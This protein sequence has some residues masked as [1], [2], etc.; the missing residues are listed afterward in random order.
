M[1]GFEM[2]KY[3]ETE[4]F[5]RPTDSPLKVRRR[6][7]TPFSESND[8]AWLVPGQPCGCL[9]SCAVGQIEST[10]GAEAIV[11]SYTATTPVCA[12]YGMWFPPCLIPKLAPKLCSEVS[13]LAPVLAGAASGPWAS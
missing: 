13:M 8:T 2:K 3:A 5:V 12:G 4:Q 11:V 1:K 6:C 7:Q 10:S 9:P